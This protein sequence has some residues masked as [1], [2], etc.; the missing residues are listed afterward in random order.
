MKSSIILIIII[1]PYPSS[2][3]ATIVQAILLIHL[4]LIP[5]NTGE[6]LSKQ[7]ARADQRSLLTQLPIAMKSSLGDAIPS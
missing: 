4:Y 6:I 3:T 7:D 1:A 5:I 2:A